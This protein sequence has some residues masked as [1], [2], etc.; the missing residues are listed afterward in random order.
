VKARVLVY[1]ALRAASSVAHARRILG[2]TPLELRA[3]VRT[4]RLDAA[5]V[6]LERGK[7][8]QHP[9]FVSMDGKEL[10]DGV[11][12]VV[13]RATNSP[14]GN[15]RWEVK[16]RACGHTDVFEGIRLREKRVAPKCR[17]CVALGQP[18]GV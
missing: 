13:S 12:T 16:F 15:A 10:F 11:L 17:V 3:L 5:F 8:W 14:H 18:G 7:Y 2:V 9:C 4:Y 1:E 6:R